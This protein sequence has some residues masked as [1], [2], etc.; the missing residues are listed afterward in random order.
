MR[1]TKNQ[2]MRADSNVMTRNFSTRGLVYYAW[3]GDPGK[4]GTPFNTLDVSNETVHSCAVTG[5]TWTAQGRSFD[6]LDDSINCGS[7]AS[8]DN[9]GTTGNFN[10]TV[11]AWIRPSSQGESN[12][13]HIC[14]KDGTA[15]VGFL[16]RM[17]ATNRLVVG[18]RIGGVST[19]SGSLNNAIT[20][21]S[22]NHVALCFN[23]SHVWNYVNLVSSTPTAAVGTITAHAAQ[24]L[25]VG[26]SA[27]STRC[28]DGTIGEIRIY[29]QVA[30][31][32]ADVTKDYHA[33]KWRYL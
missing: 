7:A 10:F 32:L 29:A 28:F 26:D 20:L 11:V 3:F 13:G 9:I 33:T 19:E 22:F 16:M 21:N 14:A 2:W 5:S 18:V 4:S 25:M 8:L 27:N 12:L 31:T 30:F 15:S 1:L 17:G 23:A 24:N 6:G